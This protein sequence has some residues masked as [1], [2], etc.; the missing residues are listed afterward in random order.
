MESSKPLETT[1]RAIDAARHRRTG[2][3]ATV[4]PEIARLESAVAELRDSGNVSHRTEPAL[5][6][7]WGD[8]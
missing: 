7:Y 8:G 4:A 6:T 1:R 2:D 5:T 3:S